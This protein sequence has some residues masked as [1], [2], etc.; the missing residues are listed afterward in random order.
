MVDKSIKG[1]GYCVEEGILANKVNMDNCWDLL[2]FLFQSNKI[3]FTNRI[4]S[5]KLY[6]ATAIK[7]GAS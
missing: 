4:V 1:G 6:M 3:H 7:V 5:T 2:L